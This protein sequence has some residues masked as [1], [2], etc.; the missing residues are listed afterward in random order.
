[1][2]ISLQNKSDLLFNIN[3]TTGILIKHCPVG[4]QPTGF[5]LHYYER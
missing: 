4:Q 2:L 5:L 1:M 3:R